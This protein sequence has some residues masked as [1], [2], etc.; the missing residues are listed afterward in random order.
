MGAISTT[1][2]YIPRLQ[3]R[4]KGAAGALLLEVGAYLEITFTASAIGGRY[5]YHP[6]LYDNEWPLWSAGTQQNV[7]G[8]SYAQSEAP[9]V[10]LKRFIPLT[11][12]RTAYSAWTA[13]I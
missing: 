13:W 8:F 12:C 1:G 7:T 6:T 11:A 2:W 9:K 5:S 10:A 3:G 4:T